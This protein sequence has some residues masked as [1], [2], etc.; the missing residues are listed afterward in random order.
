MTD[1]SPQLLSLF[2]D[3]FGLSLHD[4]HTE[5]WRQV[6]VVTYTLQND[7]RPGTT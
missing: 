2:Y 5:P 4:S 1:L 7:V 6:K 3:F